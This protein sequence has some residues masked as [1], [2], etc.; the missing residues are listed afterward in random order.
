MKQYEPGYPYLAD[1]PITYTY[2]AGIADGK[3]YIVHTPPFAITRGS[4]TRK[5]V[6]RP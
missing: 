5:S 1:L 2:S 3:V 4:K 6:P